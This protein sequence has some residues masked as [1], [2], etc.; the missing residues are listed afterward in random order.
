MNRFL[1]VFFLF[2]IFKEP[3]ADAQ[4][5]PGLV[6]VAGTVSASDGNPLSGV[7][8]TPLLNPNN[9]AATGADGQ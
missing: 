4:E 5:Q 2:L 7:S 8:V 3:T 9:R 1:C 6:G